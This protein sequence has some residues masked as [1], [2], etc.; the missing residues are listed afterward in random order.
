[1]KIAKYLNHFGVDRMLKA[2]LGDNLQIFRREKERL[3]SNGEE[4]FRNEIGVDFTEG[5]VQGDDW[6]LFIFDDHYTVLRFETSGAKARRYV[7]YCHGTFTEWKEPQEV[8]NAKLKDVSVIYTDQFKRSLTETWRDFTVHDA[9]VLPIALTSGAHFSKP[10]SKNG[11]VALIGNDYAGVCK[12]YPRWESF[13]KPAIKHLVKTYP[14]NLDVFGY[15]D[16]P[17]NVEMFGDLRR[18]TTKIRGHTDLSGSVH[19]SATASIGFVLAECFAAGIPVV[20]TPKYQ[21]P[22]YGWRCVYSVE[23]VDREVAKLIADPDYAYKLGL[24][25]HNMYS[26]SFPFQAYKE[27]LVAWLERQC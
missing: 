20:A 14:D 16:E 15:N 3:D 5:D 9:T 18:G 24:E 8:F 19:L 10:M 22:D 25:G 13:A 17:L 2:A 4:W 21:L 7:W 6:D 26:R 23:Q 1:L 27:R 12:N 11:R